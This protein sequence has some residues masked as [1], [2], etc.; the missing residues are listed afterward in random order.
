MSQ[1]VNPEDQE[2]RGFL[3]QFLDLKSKAKP[4]AKDCARC[5]SSYEHF[6]TQFW[7]DGDDQTFSI[8]LP[9]CPRCNPE[10]LSRVR[11]S[12]HLMKH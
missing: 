12:G 1:L 4:S 5:G 8:W 10:L 6:L 7:L 3:K 11:G 9:F 2:L